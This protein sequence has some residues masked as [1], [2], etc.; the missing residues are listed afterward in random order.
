MESESM[1]LDDSDTSNEE[2]KVFAVECLS[3]DLKQTIRNKI[4]DVIVQKGVSLIKSKVGTAGNGRLKASEWRILFSVY[5]PLVFLDSLFETEPQ[6]HLLLVNTTALIKCTEIVGAKSINQEEAELFAQEYGV[7]QTT[8]SQLF[9][10]IKITPNHHYS[11]HIPEQLMRWGPLMGVSEFGGERLIGTLVKFKN[12][13]ING[14]VEETIMKKFGGIQRLQMASNTYK[15]M[16]SKEENR[17]K[18]SN[19]KELDEKTYTELLKHL[20]KKV[21]TLQDY[22]NL[23]YEG[24]VLQNYITEHNDLTWRFGLKVSKSS[25]NDLIYIKKSINEIQFGNVAHILDLEKEALHQG[26][27]LLVHWLD[28]VKTRDDGFERLD[29]ILRD[30]K[31]KHLKRTN[32][33]SFIMISDILGLGAYRNL[34]AWALGCSDSTILACPINKLVGL[35]AF[36]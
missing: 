36:E 26:P 28:D 29:E 4:K 27:I 14:A 35:E 19:R 13:S 1:D 17:S 12:N 10:N 5:I 3:N 25:P 21:S 9:K 2:S 15:A 22:R 7:Y 24:P 30:W 16:I 23:P 11:M 31:I 18:T 32:T 8:S 34:P 20:Q 6:N 33:F